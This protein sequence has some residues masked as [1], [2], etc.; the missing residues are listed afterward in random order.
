MSCGH[1]HVQKTGYK[2][3]RLRRKQRRLWI[4]TVCSHCGATT[5]TQRSAVPGQ[6]T[7]SP[8]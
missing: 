5:D 6:T 3:T 4:Q 7:K 8:K 1:E 2:T